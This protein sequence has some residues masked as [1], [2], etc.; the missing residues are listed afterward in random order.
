ME[1][2]KSLILDLPAAAG[3]AHNTTFDVAEQDAIVIWWVAEDAAGAG[4]L[5][6]ASCRVLVYEPS[7]VALA[8][9]VLAADVTVASGEFNASTAFTARRYDTRG[10]N[11][12]SVQCT[13]TAVTDLK[14]YVNSFIYS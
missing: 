14:V 8:A 6:A 9:T 2:R 13:T 3:A 1:N 11:K 4:D 5:T 7:G 10:L 12:L